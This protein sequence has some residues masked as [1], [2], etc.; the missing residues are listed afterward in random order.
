MTLAGP[1]GKELSTPERR[2]V[3]AVAALA[4]AELGL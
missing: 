2:A 1:V 4:V 3:V